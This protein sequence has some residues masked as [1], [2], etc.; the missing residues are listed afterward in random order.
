MTVESTTSGNNKRWYVLQAFSGFENRVALMLKERIQANN[1]EQFFGQVLVPTEEVISNKSGKRHK[2]ERKF[3]PGY[4]F[5]EMEMNEDTWQLVRSVPKILGFI[6]GKAEKPEPITQAEANAI[7]GRL[8]DNAQNPR[9][10]K[11]FSVGEVVRVIDGPFAEFTGTVEAIDYEK[12]KLKVSI[13]I[14]GRET[15]IDLDFNQVT[16]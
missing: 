6:G 9:H 7:L 4:V 8:S 2:S 10:L 5:V 16:K 11:E 1:M 14:F 3:F 12:D 13:S 15:P